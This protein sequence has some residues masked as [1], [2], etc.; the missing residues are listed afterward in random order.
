M[1][2]LQLQD[3]NN[4]P[5][6]STTAQRAMQSTT[7]E[8][9]QKR[10]QTGVIQSAAKNSAKSRSIYFNQSE[11]KLTQSENQVKNVTNPKNHDAKPDNI[12]QTGRKTAM[13]KLSNILSLEKNP[14]LQQRDGGDNDISSKK[15]S[16]IMGKR[17]FVNGNASN[18][19]MENVEKDINSLFESKPKVRRN[20]DS[21]MKNMTMKNMKHYAEQAKEMPQ[22]LDE[23]AI[24]LGYKKVPLLEIDNLPRGGLSIDTSAVGRIQFGIP[25]ETIKDSMILGMEVP[26]YYIVPIERFCREMGPALGINLSEFE[27]PAYFNYF[28]HGNQCTLIV[29]SEGAENNIRDVFGETLLGPAQF[30]NHDSPRFNEDEDFDPTYPSDARPTFTRSSIGSDKLKKLRFLMNYV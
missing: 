15:K 13:Q 30:R 2:L 9:S 20:I 18:T 23:P 27:F 14:S 10:I 12:Y 7:L 1:T 11:G 4:P 6:S 28:V 5:K 3:S 22:L 26:K 21:S 17:R 16:F 19:V 8:V 24:G 25:P 29:D